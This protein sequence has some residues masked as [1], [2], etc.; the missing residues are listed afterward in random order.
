[1]LI[2]SSPWRSL[3]LITLLASGVALAASEDLDELRTSDSN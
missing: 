2:V 1:M 3:L